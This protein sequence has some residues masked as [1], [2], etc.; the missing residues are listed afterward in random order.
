[1]INF[2]QILKIS[3]NLR[4]RKMK[5]QVLV[6][7]A[8]ILSVA[9]FA[10]K[11][12]LKAADKA[13][14]NQ[15]YASAKSSLTQA[16][17]LI[18]NADE[19]LQ[20]KYYY[21]KAVTYTN[22]AKADPSAYGVAADSYDKLFALEKDMGKTTYTVKAEPELNAM[23]SEVS[24]KGIASYQNKDYK[25]AKSEL[26]QVYNLSKKDTAFLEYAANSAYLDKDYDAALDY[27][28]KLKDLG[29]TGITIDYT[30][31]NTETGKVEKFDSKQQYDLM[32][33]SKTHTDFK[34]NPTESKRA[35]VIK[36][37]AYVHIEKGDVEEA[38]NA[39]QNARKIAPKD[40]S[41]IMTE[42]N[43]HIKL[44]QKEE[45][46]KLMNEAIALDPTNHILYYN[47]GVIS[48]ENGDIEK[49]KEYYRKAI[50][51]NPDYIDAYINLGSAML[52]GDKALVEEMN[53]NLNNFDKYDEIKARQVD[54]YKEVIPV[55]EKAYEIKP[56]DLD[57][58]RT[59]MSLYEN[60]EM[61]DKF[62][63]MRKIYEAMK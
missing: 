14:K 33:K 54:L 5:K 25:A 13:V 4:K 46:A 29:Y 45:F 31:K 62:T 39:V 12:E 40:V 10:Q 37:I 6:L 35:S 23:I 47:L 56:D 43:L 38:I 53:N 34:E 28:T 15:D 63:E 8:M 26:Y 44:D 52:E 9:T 59:L 7:L 20:T 36:N 2:A 57:T 19:K 18:A 41:L 11:N 49:A 1:M 16:E 32:K 24:K 21:L 3:L 30:A 51:L 61:D 17:P 55:Y 22:L 48:A 27:F 58:V 60:A 42:A 50:E